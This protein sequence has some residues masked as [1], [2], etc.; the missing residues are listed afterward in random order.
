[1]VLK[2]AK[3]LSHKNLTDDVFELIV[4][5]DDDFSFEAGQFITIKIADGQDGACLR[6]YSIASPPQNKNLDF[7]IKIIPNGR[8]SNWLNS[9][10]E[11]DEFEFIG[12]N[13]KFTF[14]LPSE[15]EVLLIATGT[16]IVPFRSIIEDQ[17]SKNSTQSIHL[18]WGLRYEKDIFYSD[19]FEK[20]ASTHKNFKLDITLSQP[21][22][23]W[24]GHTGR[25]TDFLEKTTIDPAVTEIYLCGLKEMID[26]VKNI[27]IKKNIP[28]ET[29]HFEKYD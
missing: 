16:G 1:M 23:T 10:R 28:E 15:K 21:E 3:V 17:I 11:G 14:S 7:I 19:I 24:S 4:S 26:S 2:K 8:G 6:A 25:V 22:A 13:G 20:I 27:L 29:I 9:L 5:T 12:P 18:V